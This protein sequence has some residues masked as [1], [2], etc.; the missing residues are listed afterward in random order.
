[1][2][3]LKSVK[4]QGD[5]QSYI[6][7]MGRHKQLPCY[8]TSFCFFNEFTI[9]ASISLN[10]V[11][12]QC[13]LLDHKSL[14][15]WKQSRRELLHPR[16]SCLRGESV[17]RSGE[18]RAVR[19]RLDLS[20]NE[21]ATVLAQQE[22]TCSTITWVSAWSTILNLPSKWTLHKKRE[23]LSQKSKGRH[24][25]HGWSK[26][27]SLPHPIRDQNCLCISSCIHFWLDVNWNRCNSRVDLSLIEWFRARIRGKLSKYR[28]L[29]TRL[30]RPWY[31]RL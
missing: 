23:G 30:H 20:T 10:H 28:Y 7:Y 9:A 2:V 17:V 11:W 29:T 24:V 16:L 22:N 18:G 13:W 31:W 3:T 19:G 15:R 21:A 5:P 27:K 6:W 12:S 8:L 26:E 1:M 25:F 14:F 4:V